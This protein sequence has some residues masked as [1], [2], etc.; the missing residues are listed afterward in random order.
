M[1][2]ASIDD[3]KKTGEFAKVVSSLITSGRLSSSIAQE[4][5][6]PLN[7]II[8]STNTTN[9]LLLQLSRDFSTDEEVMDIVG[10]IEDNLARIDEQ[11]SQAYKMLLKVQRSINKEGKKNQKTDVH[12]VLLDSL[13]LAYKPK[14]D[15]KVRVER[16]FDESLL[17]F[18]TNA[19]ELSRVFTHII[20]NAIEAMQE[21][22]EH[23]MNFKPVLGLETKLSGDQLLISIIDNG[24]GIP[25]KLHNKI[26][27]Q[28]YT[29]KQESNHL[30]LS[31]TMVKE[32]VENELYGTIEVD[33]GPEWGTS[34]DITLT[35]K[36]K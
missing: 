23:D 32:L 18:S 10:S 20:D 1:S 17:P 22:S 33:S 36:E 29:T 31:L 13:S 35:V 3:L 15:F 26:F 27:E 6:D 8:D 2:K 30:G 12:E 19:H 9:E 24:I 16:K 25:E 5:Q 4:L 11:A 14:S 34:M 21:K 7:T 28:F